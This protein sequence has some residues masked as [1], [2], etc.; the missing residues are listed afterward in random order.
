MKHLKI[1]T[2]L[3]ALM[4]LLST[5]TATA[6]AAN[7]I[8]FEVKVSPAEVKAGEQI[9]LIV[10]LTGYTAEAAMTDAVRGLQVDI[11]GID[12]SVL[13]VVEYSSLIE[14]TSAISNKA[15]YNELL[16]RVRLA[17]VQIT[18]SLPAPCSDVLKVVFQANS[19]L[20][21]SS[22]VTP[23]VTVKIQMQSGKQIT[24]TSDE[25]AQSA[26]DMNGDGLVNTLDLI[27]LMKYIS[28]IAV[29][30]PESAGDV[31]GDGRINTLD[32]IRLMKYIN[33]EDVKL[34][35]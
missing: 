21:D 1:T 35:Q 13:S 4:L 29:D 19:D 12:T 18:D 27:R 5:F 22:S 30:I 15:S 3:L 9:E 10:A 14:D 31:N 2:A 33:G 6:Y 28:G 8:G 20:A 25:S 7:A 11:T 23:L 17:Y 24:L 16:P 26:G 34:G 32:L